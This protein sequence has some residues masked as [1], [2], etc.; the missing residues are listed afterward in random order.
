MKTFRRIITEVA[1]PS[2]EDEL[3][4]K[5]KHVIDHILDPNSEED[6]FT[7]D[8]IAKFY[9]RADYKK[10][11]DMAVYEGVTLT[12]RDL[13]GQED[14]DVNNDGTNSM[15][16]A[17]LKYRRHAQI[18]NKIIDEGA[19]FVLPEEILATEKNAFFTAAANAH[20]AGKSHFMFS[21]K[22]Y[23]VTMSK[24]AA[25][26]FSGKGKRMQEATSLDAKNKRL[27]ANIKRTEKRDADAFLFDGDRR[28]YSKGA[29]TPD[30]DEAVM[31]KIVEA[32][33]RDFK[34]K[35]VPGLYSFDHYEHPNGSFIQISPHGH[36]VYRDEQGNHREFDNMEQLKSMFAHMNESKMTPAEMKKREEIVMSMK[37]NA[38]DL[39][40]R[41]GKDWEG[42]MYAIATKQAMNEESLTNDEWEKDSAKVKKSKDSK[43]VSKMIE[44]W[45]SRGSAWLNHPA[46]TES[47][48]PV[49]QEDD[50]INNDGKVDNSDA[51]LRAR[52]KAIARKLQQEGLM[53]VIE[54]I[55]GEYGDEER[56][57]VAYKKKNVSNPDHRGEP[58]EVKESLLD[59]VSRD[60]ATRAAHAFSDKADKAHAKKD[61]AG[62][63]KGEAARKI[64]VDKVTGHAKVPA[65][66][67]NVPLPKAVEEE[68]EQIHEVSKKT[69]GR[70]IKAAGPDRERLMKR[71]KET[72]QLGHDF[73]KDGDTK[74]AQ[75]LFHRAGGDVLKAANRRSGINKAVDKLAKED[76]SLADPKTG[77]RVY[78]GKTKKSQVAEAF[79]EGAFYFDDGSTAAIFHEEAVILNSLFES[80]DESNREK[81]VAIAT[82]C[83]AGLK[84][85]VRFAKEVL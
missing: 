28:A 23:P 33:L 22:K 14:D 56:S 73:K 52:R 71:A 63:K 9:N 79:E 35:H 17:Q 69:L 16:D 4:F 6:Q 2:S 48:D 39:K 10:G 26:T 68:V 65:V 51:Y 21:G 24:G 58:I 5:E 29:Q 18:K 1:Q 40:K 27:D 34:A 55:G 49:G 12:R 42:V 80:L 20:K 32:N 70:Y 15:T 67:R 25:K 60:L 66:P 19:K 31:Q 44:K 41:Y 53:D 57:H 59:E 81:M 30:M 47:M 75:E 7:A 61:Y 78:A 13:P 64:A 82:S 38:S 77:M 11:E 85:I 62:Y 36:G 45:G 72:S 76:V 3:N 84:D 43:F 46:L 83:E 74:K 54:P 8:E 50:D 37:K